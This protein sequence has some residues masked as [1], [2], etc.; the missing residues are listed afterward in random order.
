MLPLEVVGPGGSFSMLLMPRLT[1]R[2][3]VGQGPGRWQRRHTAV[4]RRRRQYL[5]CRG[6][7]LITLLPAILDLW[8]ERQI[9][10]YL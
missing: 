9:K 5:K 3:P 1:G 6:V 8:G 4:N 7:F 10:L 2:T